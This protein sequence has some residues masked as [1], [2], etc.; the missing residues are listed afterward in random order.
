MSFDSGE[1]QQ[2]RKP[3]MGGKVPKDRATLVEMRNRVGSTIT[4]NASGETLKNYLEA[5]RAS[6]AEQDIKG[7]YGIFSVDGAQAGLRI[8]SLLFYRVD[9]GKVAVT[10][11]LVEGTCGALR[12]QV[13]GNQQQRIELPFPVANLYEDALIDE[14]LKHLARH[15]NVNLDDTVAVSG[16]VIPKELD[17]KTDALSIRSIIY[18]AVNAIDNF[19]ND[20][21]ENADRWDLST[22]SKD[23]VFEGRID[24]SPEP[25]FTHTG[26]PC[27]ADYVIDVIARENDHK[28]TSQAFADDYIIS[29]ATAYVDLMYA[30]PKDIVDQAGR[31]LGK[32]SQV[33]V[34]RITTTSVQTDIAISPEMY[35]QGM[36]SVFNLGIGNRDS[37]VWMNRF[38]V[39]VDSNGISRDLRTLSYECMPAPIDPTDGTFAPT[40]FLREFVDVEPVYVLHA[41]DTG[42]FS[43]ITEVI[44]GAAENSRDRAHAEKKRYIYD[45]MQTVCGGHFDWDPAWP[46]CTVEE[47][48]KVI[49]G[50]WPDANNVY[51]DLRE[52]DLLWTYTHFGATEFE[53]CLAFADTFKFNA[54]L[55]QR[56][57]DRLQLY[58]QMISCSPII[59]GYAVPVIWEPNFVTAAIDGIRKAGGNLRFDSLTYGESRGTRE[60]SQLRQYSVNAFAAYNNQPNAAN[61]GYHNVQQAPIRG[62]F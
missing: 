52:I 35:M 19:F 60:Y 22:L 3:S 32:S 58:T 18:C 42:P 41:E 43:F 13:Y 26:L 50:R 55:E 16:M 39:A 1:K 45:A 21:D 28:P 59:D 15:L 6:L 36:I 44:V 9:A 24:F 10:T 7:E 53:M 17:V 46:I 29:R 37:Q 31:F 33:Y 40:E 38:N 47:N 48:S 25:Q 20:M 14:N 5:F 12:P 11:L 51:R 54:P 57:A 56:L 34:P 4:R 23:V 27:R 49:L 8:S 61:Y 30:G 2:S 62:R